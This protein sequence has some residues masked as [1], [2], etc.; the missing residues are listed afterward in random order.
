MIVIVAVSVAEA[1]AEAVDAQNMYPS[2]ALIV[3][4]R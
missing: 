3:W 2:F 1:E 4:P